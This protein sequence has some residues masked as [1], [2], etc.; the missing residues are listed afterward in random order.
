[1]KLWKIFSAE[2]AYQVRRIS[3]WLYLAVLVVFTLVMNGVTTPGDGV[4]A[5]NTFHITAITVM[6]G[7]IWLVMAAAIAGEAG[8]RDV[9]TRMYPLIYTTPVSKLHYLGGRFLAAFAVNALLVL[10]LPVGTLLSFYLPGM[11]PDGLLPFR[12][13]AY[14]SVY[15]LIALPGAF[16]ATAL[17]FSF[18][19]LSRRVMTSY[20]A[21]LL[22]ALVAQVIAIT[23]AKLFGNWD[24]VKLLDPVGVAGIVGNELQTWTPTQK[25]TQLVTLEGMFLWNRV[26]WGSVAAGSLL[27]TYRRFSFTHPVTNSWWSRFKRRP[28]LPAQTSAETALTRSTPIVV[29][30][31]QRTF[32][33]ATCFRQAL[34][35]AGA[36][37]RKIAWS[38]IGLSLVGAIALV[39]AVFG[40]RIMTQFGIPLIP[41]TQQVVDYLTNPVGNIGTPL[42]VIPLLIM[43]FAGELVWR[44]RDAGQMDIG[45]AA[46]VSEWVHF[47][48]KFLGLSL[49]IVAWMALLMAGGILMQLGLHYDKL[50]ISL[51]VQA[52][53]GFQ[54]I[55]Y[56]LFTLLAL[57][58]H[59]VVNQKNI[60][61]VVV[62]IVFLFIA[63]PSKFGVEHNL[64]IFGAAPG[65]WYTDMR[66]FGPTLGPWLWFKLYWLAWALLLAVAARLLWV[67]GREQ[68]F[69]R[70]LQGARRRFTRSTCWVALVGAGLVLTLGSFIF[71]NTNV[72]NEYQTDSDSHERK[73]AYERCY[74]RYR[75]T[76]QPQL[77]ATKLYVEIYPDRQQAEI[78]ARYTLVNKDTVPIDSI[79][80]GSL[81]GIE[82]VNVRF[83]RRARGVLTDNELGY[84]IYA[85]ERPL[86]SGD[87]L[88]LDF[89]VH[90]KERGFRHDGTNA[91]VV[92]NG[93]CFTN[94]DLLPAI[95]YQRY[96][97]LNDPVIRKK[98]KLAA[99]PAIPSLYD[100]EARKKPFSTD[101]NTFEAI[102]STA[103]DEVAVAPGRLHQT[104]TKGDRRYFHFKTEAPIG[105]EYS[106]LSGKYAVQESRWNDVAI[107]IYYHPDHALNIDRMHRSIKASLA[108]FTEQFG[109]YPYGHITVVERAG[110]GG[111]ASADASMIH[112]GEQY[113]LMKPDDSPDGFD[114]PY[115]ILAHEVAH[116]WWGIASLTPAYV[117]GAG[118]LVEGLAVYSGMQVLEMNYGA[119]H[120]QQFLDYLHS[121][122]EM[123]RSLATP[124]L[125]QANEDFLY[126]RKGGLAMYTLSKYIGKEKV[127]GAL[128]LLLQKHRSG[129]LP[130][131]TTLDLYQELQTVTPD[132]LNYLLHDLFEQNTYW[133][134]K[135]EQMAAVQTERGNWQV[136]LKVQA[137][138]VVID[139]AG[140]EKEV[141]MNDWLEVGLYEEGKRL[142][143]PL[144]LQL[145]RIRSGEQTIKVTVPRKPERGGIDPNH[146][147]IDLRLDDNISQLG[148]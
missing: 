82:P 111:G 94:Y 39:S 120:L 112:Y 138:K 96:R 41:T 50:D 83:N 143:E 104:W 70:R 72:L 30:P 13:W 118:V 132:S 59:V 127:N 66:G 58:V 20:M 114:L 9:Q 88:Q 32:G 84:H 92:K 145:H 147:M 56:L 97:E 119:G 136:T 38:P 141:P 106:F 133:R 124:S 128:R 144:Y 75:N 113:S 62:L 74:G 79:H 105:G 90:Y 126:Y 64:L 14:G 115:Y 137:H 142:H 65:W 146:L 43:Y 18:A 44:E 71:Y 10:S 22:L 46:P 52:L 1:M 51:Y 131:P 139:R 77:T 87:S 67:R 130:Q 95:G 122:Y 89:E 25:N 78:R 47:S 140:A 19:A 53:F 103:K 37:F 11:N 61:Y 100:R 4:Y 134:L 116:Q 80:V 121:F 28:N 81:S 117:E 8:A 40:N 76:P 55:D 24:L 91:L 148:G 31:V 7:L 49:I 27:L 34:T 6:G 102:V 98:Y 63:F 23:A 57:A 17:Q 5:N 12:P 29:P 60:G 85:L 42:V 93:T 54:L 110:A 125:L 99:R 21:S 69:K 129:A 15:F 33:F 26:L 45:D 108:Y 86:Q 48:G 3:T 135:T 68:D 35:I 101:Q 107:R 73:A 2:F 36:S 123:P 16:V 109:S